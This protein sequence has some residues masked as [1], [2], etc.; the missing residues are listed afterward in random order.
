MT[1]SRRKYLALAACLS[2]AMLAGCGGDRVAGGVGAVPAS[3]AATSGNLLYV[4]HLVGKYRDYRGVLS[5]LTFPDGKPVMTI[6]LDGFVTAVCSDTSGNVWAVVA[7]GLHHWNAFEYPHG[8]TKPV[9]QIHIPHPTYADGCAVDP[10]TGNLAVVTGEFQGSG[11][12]AHAD[13]WA[14]ARSGK[15]KM[16]TLGFSPSACAY[17]DKGNLFVVGYIGDTVTFELAELKH[18]A[19]S[20]TDISLYHRLGFYPGGVQ[21]DGKYLAVAPG[22]VRNPPRIFRLRIEGSIAKVADT[23]FLDHM[24]ALGPIT[25]TNGTIAAVSGAQGHE[26]ALWPYPSGGAPEKILLRSRLI[27]RGLAISAP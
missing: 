15:P 17:D 22:P 10:S 5:V 2:V 14:G 1:T 27:I 13:V 12:G 26:V 11:P 19:S 24:Y 21:W 6:A 20:F 16:Y 23:V 4:A 25:V 18:G 8:G 3:S 7:D 9:A